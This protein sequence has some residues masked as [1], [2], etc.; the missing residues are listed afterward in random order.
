LSIWVKGQRSGTV[1]G[2]TRKP[3]ASAEQMESSRQCA[4][5]ER[6]A[7]EMELMRELPEWRMESVKLEGVKVD[8]GSLIYVG[9]TPYS[10]PSWLISKQMEAGLF[11]NHVEV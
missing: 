3:L 6:V 9:R 2:A 8:S 11:M 7:E 4:E 1:Q 5:L 10:V